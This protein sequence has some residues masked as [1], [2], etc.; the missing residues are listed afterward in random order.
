V[1][2]ILVEAGNL[3]ELALQGAVMEESSRPGSRPG[4]SVTTWM[5]G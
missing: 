3:P 5:V 1:E 4:Y 2:D